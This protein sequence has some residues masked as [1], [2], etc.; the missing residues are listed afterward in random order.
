MFERSS[1]K[2]NCHESGFDAAN[3]PKQEF[4]TTVFIPSRLDP[5]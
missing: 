4:C 2:L 5:S 1:L 3:G